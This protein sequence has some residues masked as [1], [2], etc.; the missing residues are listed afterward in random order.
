M[1]ISHL[2]PFYQL[3]S[4]NDH[5]LDRLFLI[6]H[7]VFSSSL[8]IC[9]RRP[10][11]VCQDGHRCSVICCDL[12]LFD[13]VFFFLGF[14]FFQHVQPSRSASTAVR[15]SIRFSVDY[16]VVSV[17]LVLRCRMRSTLGLQSLGD[18]R[19]EGKTRPGHKSANHADVRCGWQR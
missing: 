7:C 10:Y 8:A 9:S 16:F 15:V 6:C 11:T 5:S 17:R 1:K 19:V 4:H 3:L 14:I 13:V 12:I 2:L 18:P